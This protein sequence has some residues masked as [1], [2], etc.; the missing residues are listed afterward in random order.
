MKSTLNTLLIWSWLAVALSGCGHFDSPVEIHLDSHSY[1]WG[2]R[3]R[4]KYDFEEPPP[5][6][7]V[8]VRIFLVGYQ[9]ESGTDTVTLPPRTSSAAPWSTSRSA[10]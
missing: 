5:G 2:D 4:A 8:P 7:T 6:V 10:Q 9:L 3:I 1:R